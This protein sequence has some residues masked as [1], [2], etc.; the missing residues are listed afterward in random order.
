MPPFRRPTLDTVIVLGVAFIHAAWGVMLSVSAAPSMTTPIHFLY[1]Q[2]P[3]RYALGAVLIAIS[4][5]AVLGL[6]Y[7]RN[8][9]QL[10]ACAIPQ[11]I[12]LL[13][14]AFGG[15]TAAYT[16]QYADGVE[17]PL[18]FILPDQLPAITFALLHVGVL[19]EVGRRV[20]WR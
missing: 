5:F 10:W 18:L 4:A 14:T 9:R 3:N 6:L 17:R 7:A 1:R 20:Q 19:W 16:R 15:V 12:V 8:T 11:Q 2:L 13:L